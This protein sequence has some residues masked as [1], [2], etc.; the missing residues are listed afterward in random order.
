MKDMSS[1]TQRFQAVFANYPE[2]PEP[3]YECPWCHDHGVVECYT[4]NGK[5]YP[6]KFADRFRM[7]REKRDCY[8]VV[9]ACRHCEA[10][11]RVWFSGRTAG[12]LVSAER[13]VKENVTGVVSLSGT[14]E[15][16]EEA[17]FSKAMIDRA[18]QTLGIRIEK[19]AGRWVCE[20]A[21]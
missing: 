7:Y 8:F 10:G 16:A 6:F 1:L 18:F 19:L 21:A 5:N 11:K 12:S 9:V 15:K 4:E 13:W 14:Y 3:R 20:P 17:G 2:N